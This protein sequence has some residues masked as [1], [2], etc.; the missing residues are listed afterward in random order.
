M[1]S[2]SAPALMYFPLAQEFLSAG[3]AIR[4]SLWDG[5]VGGHELAWIKSDGWFDYYINAAGAHIVRSSVAGGAAGDVIGTDLDAGDWTC[6]TPGCSA[7]DVTNGVPCACAGAAALDINQPY[8]AF[9]DISTPPAF[10]LQ[11]P[12]AALGQMGCSPPSTGCACDP[13]DPATTGGGSGG[14]STGGG[15]GGGGGG[16]GG[17]DLSGGGGGGSIGD[18]V[19]RI[20]SGGLGDDGEDGPGSPGSSPRTPRKAPATTLVVSQVGYNSWTFTVSL[21]ADPNAQPGEVWTYKILGPTSQSDYGVIASGTL[22]PGDTTSPAA[23]TWADVPTDG[24]PY[25]VQARCRLPLVGMESSDDQQLGVGPNHGT[26]EGDLDNT[27]IGSSYDLLVHVHGTGPFTYQ[28]YNSFGDI[29][30]GQTTNVLSGTVVAALCGDHV[31][32]T[33]LNAYGSLDVTPHIHLDPSDGLIVTVSPPGNVDITAAQYPTYNQAY[34]ARVVG[35]VPPY[36]QTWALGLIP[37]VPPATDLGTSDSA[38]VTHTDLDAQGGTPGPWPSTITLY[39][40]V[41]DS[42]G[43]PNTGGMSINFVGIA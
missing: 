39:Y 38:T 10:D 37:T 27:H 11:N 17:A 43:S 32:C 15:S 30:S 34:A 29:L 26:H 23:L 4:R 6:L 42:A 13:A 20:L 24:G 19:A 40:N 16:G 31:T 36:A 12:N 33:V 8:P 41:Q 21:A 7:L 3:Y 28:W 35:G 9:N 5:S 14:G 18:T 1:S 2:A 25:K 22:A